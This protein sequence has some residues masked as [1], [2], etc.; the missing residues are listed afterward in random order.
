MQLPMGR[1]L[2]FGFGVPVALMALCSLFVSFRLSSLVDY[3]IP[4]T[5]ACD[6]L[7]IGI[8]QSL[9]QLRGYTILGM[10]QQTAINFRQ[11]RQEAWLKID[12]ALARLT[13]L[14]R[15][16]A[17]GSDAQQ[18]L[19]VIA[20]ELK[21]LRA[22]QDEVEQL[23]HSEANRPAYQLLLTLATPLAETMI[24]SLTEAIDEEGRL[25]A[26]PERKKLL[27][28][29]ADCRG[30]LTSAITSTR[31]YL[32]SGDARHRADF[33]KLWKKNAAAQE[34]VVK[35]Q[36]FLTSTQNEG[37]NEYLAARSR[38]S[39]LPDQIFRLRERSDWNR[40]NHVLATKASPASEL[41]MQ[42]LQQLRSAAVRQR[43]AAAFAVT[44]TVV[45][46][47]LIAILIAATVGYFL[48]RSLSRN[49]SALAKRASDIATGVLNGEPLVDTSRDEL[50]QLAGL[51][52]QMT[53]NLRVMVG[54]MSSQEEV[55]TIL[56]STA[57]GIISINET[58]V[59][60]SFNRSAESLFGYTR[61]E[62]EGRNVSMLAPSPY[63]EEHDSYLS[64]YAQTGQAQVIGKERELEGRRKDGSTFPMSLRVTAVEKDGA[65]MY[66]GTV[67]D[68]SH[69]KDAER[70]R[71]KIEAAV[72]DAASAL[73]AA[74]SQILASTT[75]QA[76]SARQ[77]AATVTETVST[78]EEITV[79][80]GQ[81][82][83]RAREV[84]ESAQ[85]AS[86]VS[87]S[88]RD[89][90]NETRKAMDHVREQSETTA[91][92]I[93]TLAERAQAIGEIITTVNEI[94]DQTNL[95][96]LNAAIEASRAGEHGKGFAVVAS[97]IKS[98][99]EQSRKS[100]LQVRDILNEIQQ[101]TNTAVMS[102][103][104]GTRSVTDAALV[105]T[106]AEETINTLSQTI[107]EAARAA[108]QI[109][110]SAT[111]QSTGMSQIRD[112]M[113][114]IEAATRQTQSATQ[115][116]EQSAREL[117]NLGSRLLN[118]LQSDSED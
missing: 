22:A 116:S 12:A 45:S 111:Q 86:D 113:K 25:E 30:S 38:F 15:G 1:K 117:S 13:E 98:L 71:E 79:V 4:T 88:G 42:S 106:K 40:A 96:A 55:L 99:A 97:E 27:N 43:D 66:L 109:V 32:L 24:Q 37:W 48:H 18:L 93:L 68:I 17:E 82:T 14:Q 19:P 57:D 102:T 28:A 89:A 59:I 90:V 92:N 84:A 5:S 101:A 44:S 65:R 41:I 105:V 49:I 63:R 94:A 104:Q 50:G 83:D 87:R 95:L 74:S 77:Q 33:A 118:L 16:W 72:R 60:H 67:R 75:E 51:F 21:K 35:L 70:E 29:L 62:V 9:A 110:A 114:Q 61:D 107:A 23:A 2:A 46:S 76:V 58:G 26:I 91:E 36:S 112:S 81:S 31:A 34:A 7:S 85:R 73:A 64:R 11:R 3:A 115:Q 8:N 53:V 108:S 100:T 103:E 56:N 39:T 10:D 54:A 80:A 47:T 6:E 69:R 78:V 20:G 52:N